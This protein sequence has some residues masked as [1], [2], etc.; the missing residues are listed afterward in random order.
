MFYVEIGL[1]LVGVCLLVLGYRRD[2]RRT[3]L[4]AALLFLA[5]GTTG[6]FLQGLADGVRN[7]AG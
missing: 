7:W 4:A 1:L 2:D 5:A 6:G 3:L